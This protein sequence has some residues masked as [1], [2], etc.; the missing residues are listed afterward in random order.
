MSKEHIKYLDDEQL[1]MLA[2]ASIVKND[3]IVE[4]LLK[5]GS[6]LRQ[7]LNMKEHKELTG[8]LPYIE[9]DKPFKIN[10]TGDDNG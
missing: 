8:E 1:I 7:N 9:M 2:L 6:E 5:R 4:E 3:T 10:I